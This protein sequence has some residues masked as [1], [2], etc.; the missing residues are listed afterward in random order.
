MS[1]NKRLIAGGP[2]PIERFEILTWSG[3]SSQS[4]SVPTAFPSAWIFHK[5]GYGSGSTAIK[6]FNAQV[7]ENQK[8]DMY[9]SA[10]AQNNSDRIAFGATSSTMLGNFARNGSS[11]KAFSFAI[12]ASA[13]T[14]TNGTASATVYA[15][16]TK[17]IS[18]VNWS[19]SGA[20]TVGHG[21]SSSPDIVWLFPN[22]YGA[23]ITVQFREYNIGGYYGNA[24][25]YLNLGSNA[26]L[27][28]SSAHHPSNMTSTTFKAGTTSGENDTAGAGLN[29][30][31]V[32]KSKD[33]FSK[34]NGYEGSCSSNTKNVNLGFEPAGII[35]KSLSYTYPWQFIE[36]S[37][38]A[39]VT[40]TSTGF[41]MP[42][43]QANVNKC[44]AYLYMAWANK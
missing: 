29:H 41:S 15:D 16:D 11:F 20:N 13:A 44:G 4:V 28:S 27:A 26:Y 2:K 1:L 22:D 25:H 42:G 36:S 3:N 34:F 35:I 40:F 37:G 18:Y 6:H 17:G 24:T 12:D 7:S 39:G 19:A 5:E 38:D 8:N 21:L 14:N 43:N 32:F 33:G 30:A 10:F 9:E 31:F 23:D